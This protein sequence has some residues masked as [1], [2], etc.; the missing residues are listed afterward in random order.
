MTRG[1]EHCGGARITEIEQSISHGLRPRRIGKH[2]G[3]GFQRDT[4]IDQ[5]AAAKP[6]ADQ[7]MNVGAKAEIVEAGAGAGAHL[8]AIDLKL[9]AQLGQAAREL[10]GHDLAPTLDDAD[11]LS[12]ARETRGGNA[13]AIAGPDDDDVIGGLH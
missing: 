9:A 1:P 4:G 11:A 6:A 8:A 2:A 3:F 12:G 13:T 7:N 5:R 10:A